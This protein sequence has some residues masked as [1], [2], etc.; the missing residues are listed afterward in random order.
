MNGPL[1]LYLFLAQSPFLLCLAVA[2][3]SLIVAAKS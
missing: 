3:T 2:I 1:D